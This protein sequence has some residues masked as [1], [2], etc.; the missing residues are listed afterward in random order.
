MSQRPHSRGERF[1]RRLL[2]LFPAE[3][4][5]DYGDDMAATFRDQRHDVLAHGGAIAAARLWWDTIRGIL[6]T[7]PREHL[8]LLRGDVRYALRGLRRNPAFTLVAV[9]ALAIGI[10]AN[11]AVFTIVNGVLLRA[12]P[13]RTPGELVAIYEKVQGAAVPKF[14]FSAPDY[15]FVRGA[16]RSFAGMFTFRNQSLELTGAGESQRVIGARIAPEMFAVLGVAP[17]FGRALTADDD[18]QN[19][20]VAVLDYGLWTRAFGRDPQVIGRTISLDRQPY[21]VVGVMGDRF[22]FPP[23]GHGRNFEPASI[24][25]PIA[26]SAVERQAWASMYNNTLVARLGP[27]VT[28]EQ[29]RAELASLTSTLVQQ[30]PPVLQ[31]AGFLNGLTLPMSA[32]ADEIV[33]DTRRMILVLMG[34]V[35]I[36]LL[37]GC[38][39]VANLMLTRAGSRQREL[40]VRSALGASPARVVR[41]LLTEGLVLASIGGAAGLLLAWWTMGAMLSLAGDALPRAESVAF[42]RRAIAFTVVLSFATPLLFGVMPAL[43]A[44]LRSTFDALKDGAHGATG[45]HRRQRLLGGLVV[46]QFALALMLSVGAGLLARSFVRLLAASPGFRPQQVATASVQ[47]PSGRY[48]DARTVKPFYRQAV[49]A[50]RAIPGVTA[51]A[52]GTDR[53]LHIEERRTFTADATAVPMPTLNRVIAASWV[54]GS[55][56]EALGVPL[57]RGR[58]LTDTDGRAD[59]RVIVVS[60]MMARRLWPDQDPIGRQ[61]KWGIDVPQNTNPWMTVVGVVGD[62]NQ[63]ALGTEVIPQTYE[64]IEQQSNGAVNFYRRVNLVVRAGGDPAPILSAIRG[65]MQRLDPELP[66]SDAMSAADVLGESVKP[67]RFSMTV[68]GLFALVALGLAAIGIYGVLANAVTQQTHE[69]G[70]RMALGARAGDVMWSVLRRALALMAIGVAIG[71][72]GALAL[73]RVMAGL[74][75]EIHPTDAATFAGAALLLAALAVAASLVPAWRATRVDPLTA[76]RAE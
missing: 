53:P 60:E 23:R 6:T 48:P 74:L 27:G 62:V 13:Y 11:T 31:Q 7:A 19:A 16:A 55:Y 3:F 38:A 33:G 26:F 40:A 32:F 68:V 51:A 17:A 47:L 59:A 44:A 76:L 22:Q 75:F 37:I 9:L 25:L 28:V 24:F 52:A 45:G 39:D 20:K 4:R 54:A 34:A 41:Q 5:G 65:T 58:F 67:Q 18:R 14:E 56:F 69:I 61:I 36:V 71:T 43:R 66:L 72:A 30:Y 50:L 21:T 12:L 42:D 15:L 73:A 63:S 70:V 8:D 49:E 35:A 10:G 64:P 57:K 29:A 2:R 1:F 46:A